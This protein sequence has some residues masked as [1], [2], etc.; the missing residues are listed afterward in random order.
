MKR[1]RN[2]VILCLIGVTL[3]CALTSC[4]RG[5][6]SSSTNGG[7]NSPTTGTITQA[8]GDVFLNSNLKIKSVLQDMSIAPAREIIVE[9]YVDAQGNG[10]GMLGFGD[11]VCDVRV[12]KDVLYII[13]DDDTVVSVNDITGRLT[14]SADDLS[15]INDLTTVGFKVVGDVP[16][17]YSAKLGNVSMV[18]SFAQSTNT[19]EATTL[20]TDNV[21]SFASAIN[22]IIEYNSD[23]AGL[24][25]SGEDS[26]DV[27]SFYLNSPY[28]V[29]VDG[30]LYSVGDTCNPSTYFGGRTPEGLLTS[31]KYKEDAKIDFLH[32]SYISETGRSSVVLTSDYVQA[33]ETSAQFTWLGL[34][35]GTDA[36]TLKYLLGYK[37]SKK[38]LE[39]WSPIDPEL[40]VIDYKSN[41]YYCTV[42]SLKIELRCSSSAG[43][44]SIYIERPLDYVTK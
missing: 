8:L 35:K 9:L 4:K 16:I 10:E 3:L 12:V 15:G 37:L 31:S 43:L 41:T 1:I 25:D 28:G 2:G 40:Q 17:E 36:K 21:M 26:K 18:T 32:V 29:T 13:V 39:S 34:D 7:S 33:F 11:I 24:V 38:D 42:G 6:T 44:E 19:F 23:K 14:S 20:A 30:G 5:S 27:Q 22:Y